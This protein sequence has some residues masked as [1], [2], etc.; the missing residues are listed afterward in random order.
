MLVTSRK[1]IWETCHFALYPTEKIRTVSEKTAVRAKI[2]YFLKTLHVAKESFTSICET[3]TEHFMDFLKGYKTQCEEWLQE[4]ELFTGEE[5]LYA[6][7][8]LEAKVFQVHQSMTNQPEYQ[9]YLLRKEALYVR[10]Y[11]SEDQLKKKERINQY[12]EQCKMTLEDLKLRE[13]PRFNEA[14]QEIN[15]ALANIENSKKK[16]SEMS[17]K[18]SMSILWNFWIPEATVQTTLM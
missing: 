17:Y 11:P 12:A 16:Y 7:V 18:S 4:L 3:E 15:A 5:Y 9:K 13:L 6:L 2:E 10:E 1:G 14:K 8:C